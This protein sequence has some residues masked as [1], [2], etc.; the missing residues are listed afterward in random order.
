M[1]GGAARPPPL[2]RDG[3]LRIVYT[4]G[5]TGVELTLRTVSLRGRAVF[6]QDAG[7]PETLMR[8][9]LRRRACPGS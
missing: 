9:T 2:R 5:F 6:L 8:V 1:K 4:D 7:P 3:P